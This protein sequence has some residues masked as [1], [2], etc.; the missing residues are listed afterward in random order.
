MVKYNEIGTTPDTLKYDTFSSYLTNNQKTQAMSII[1]KARK[2]GKILKPYLRKNGEILL[3]DENGEAIGVVNRKGLSPRDIKGIIPDLV[4]GVAIDTIAPEIGLPVQAGKLATKVGK[5]VPKA[6]KTNLAKKMGLYGTGFG[7]SGATQESIANQFANRKKGANIGERALTDSTIGA[8]SPLLPLGVK[9]VSSGVK[10]LGTPAKKIGEKYEDYVKSGGRKQITSLAKTPEEE[11]YLAEIE[12]LSNEGI[13]GLKNK[14]NYELLKNEATKDFIS[15][16]PINKTE[17]NTISKQDYEQSAEKLRNL[18]NSALKSG[19]KAEKEAY[20]EADKLNRE[21]PI[22]SGGFLATRK[23]GKR[24][25]PIWKTPFRDE[26]GR[27]SHWDIRP[28]NKLPENHIYKIQTGLNRGLREL[29]NNFEKGIYNTSVAPKVEMLINTLGKKGGVNPRNVLEYEKNLRQLLTDVEGDVLQKNDKISRTNKEYLNSVKDII[30]NQSSKI[31]NTSPL[32]ADAYRSTKK[33]RQIYNDVENILNPLDKTVDKDI[34]NATSKILQSDRKS[35][36]AYLKPI[37]KRDV[38]ANPNNE[39][40]FQSLYGEN[41]GVKK[42]I[43]TYGTPA[44]K[45]NLGELNQLIRSLHIQDKILDKNGNIDIEKFLKNKGELINSDTFKEYFT[46]Q[47]QADIIKGMEDLE[48]IIIPKKHIPVVS[49]GKILGEGTDVL[50]AGQVGAGV[51]NKMV[52]TL[53]NIKN[54]FV[55]KARLLDL[56]KKEHTPNKKDSLPL[57]ILDKNQ[58]VVSST[59]T[60]SQ[61]P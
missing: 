54:S 60:G 13:L 2:N 20:D 21:I 59:Q 9:A 17:K 18:T 36:N 50:S 23:V 3:Q 41:G 48:K 31:L 43:N 12:N 49:I 33:A 38:L 52:R 30:D 55:N 46:K 47:E 39:A 6:L 14:S 29:N 28:V 34:T 35:L 4:T 61:E 40:I 56:L 51:T 7:L 24:N 22:H 32:G 45:N 37:L 1:E 57:R 26:N 11:N 44:L 42:L 58:G 15:K 25:Y 53:I 27:I 19:K 8:I 16:L 5:Y 10:K